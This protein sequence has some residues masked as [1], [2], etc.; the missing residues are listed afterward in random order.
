MMNNCLHL[1]PLP[2][3]LL[4]RQWT[5]WFIAPCYPDSG[6]CDLLHLAVHTAYSVIYCTLISWQCT[7]WLMYLAVHVAYGLTYCALLSMQCT[8]WFI[9]HCCPFCWLSWH[10]KFNNYVEK[11]IMNEFHSAP[12]VCKCENNK[13]WNLMV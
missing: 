1:C 2:F 12:Y 3:T 13:I 7:V 6:Q 8:V 11:I 5:V 9:A 4:S 10:S